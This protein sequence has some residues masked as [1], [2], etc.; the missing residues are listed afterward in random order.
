MT[1]ADTS[2]ESQLHHN[3]PWFFP[4][5][6]IAIDKDLNFIS[7]KSLYS[8]TV[9]GVTEAPWIAYEHRPGFGHNSCVAPL[10]WIP[11]MPLAILT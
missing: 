1:A 2:V 8:Y 5:I 7:G 10:F 9:E 3:A 6:F 4:G 11:A